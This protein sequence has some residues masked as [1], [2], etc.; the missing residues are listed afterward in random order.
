MYGK[1]LKIGLVTCAC[2][3][4]LW[5]A[6]T[7]GSH[8][9]EASFV[10]INSRLPRVSQK[11]PVN[12]LISKTNNNKTK[13]KEENKTPKQK[14]V[15]GKASYGGHTYYPRTQKAEGRHSGV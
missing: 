9:F 12:Q 5:K 3:H 15:G 6:D 10:C 1:A 11:D 13:R 14:W 2:N 7:G 4:S 8:K